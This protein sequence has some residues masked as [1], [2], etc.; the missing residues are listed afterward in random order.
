MILLCSIENSLEEH[1]SVNFYK[2]SRAEIRSVA[3]YLRKMHDEKNISWSCMALSIPDIQTYTP[4]IEREL[5]LYE[6]PF[7]LK[8]GQPL[9]SF[10]AGSFFSLAQ[11]CV[12]TDFSFDSI[13]KLLLN[14]DL[15]WKE[16]ELNLSLIKFGQDN[17]CLCSYTYN[18][19]TIDVWE[20]AFNTQ[21]QEE[22]LSTYYESLKKTLKS[23]VGSYADIY[24][25]FS[26]I[27]LSR[28]L[29]KNKIYD[30]IFFSFSSIFS[31][32]FFIS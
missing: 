22:L 9:A 6:I 26:I 16:E 13:K 3:Q 19:K 7:V 18:G 1:P 15:P 23:F 17:N 2:N 5:S 32:I 14:K 29:N 24:I 12:Q 30:F 8:S 4:Y 10:G 11:Q 31:N 21:P 27:D 20:Q 25:S 28:S